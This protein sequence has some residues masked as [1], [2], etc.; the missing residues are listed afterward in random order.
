MKNTI[1]GSLAAFII[2]SS[3]AREQKST[4][5]DLNILFAY[6]KSI[7]IDFKNKTIE[8]FYRGQSFKD[9]IL[10]TK[11]DSLKLSDAI[12][13]N[14]IDKLKGSYS[15]PECNWLMPS[16]EDKIEIFKKGKILNTI[17]INY[18]PNCTDAKEVQEL[19][20]RNRTFG[21]QIR[22]LILNKPSFKRASDSLKQFQIRKNGII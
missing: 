15:Y 20:K 21:L 16:F 8:A 5:A 22:S 3:C 7:R 4:T 11:N 10:F 2:F 6:Q 19:E 1:I 13:G 9:T 17:E 14:K 18:E 12:K